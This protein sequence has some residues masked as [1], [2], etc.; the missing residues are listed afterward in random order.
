M[1]VFAVAQATGEGWPNKLA[2]LAERQLAV[3]ETEEAAFKEE[4][5]V[6]QDSYNSAIVDLATMVGGFQQHTD[7][8]KMDAVVA[9]VEVGE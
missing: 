1:R 9:D 2:R 6:E 7:L 3:L 4:M 5:H 8:S